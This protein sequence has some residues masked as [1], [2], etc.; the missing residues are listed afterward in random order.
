MLLTTKLCS[1]HLLNR[2]SRLFGNGKNFWIF[3]EE[4]SIEGTGA[5]Y[6]NN[7]SEI[8]SESYWFAN[9]SPVHWWF[10]KPNR[11]TGRI[12]C[13]Q[14][15]YSFEAANYKFCLLN[16]LNSKSLDFSTHIF[17]FLFRIPGLMCLTNKR[18]MKN[19]LV[20]TAS[21]PCTTNDCYLSLSKNLVFTLNRTLG[22]TG[23]QIRRTR[24]LEE[25]AVGG[26]QQEPVIRIT[27]HDNRASFPAMAGC[28][29]PQ[30]PA[31]Q[32]ACTLFNAVLGPHGNS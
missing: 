4:F 20:P 14:Q 24:H 31:P 16:F 17:S 13:C 26:W 27:K 23:L 6:S 1:L 10:Y 18:T 9:S 2:L 3:S 30:G 5:K 28:Q 25:K 11:N 7:L 32:R 29:I 21:V 19:E 15:K 8:S 12:P 22:P